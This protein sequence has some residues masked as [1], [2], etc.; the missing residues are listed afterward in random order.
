GRGE[1]Y[2]DGWSIGSIGPHN[3][4]INPAGSRVYMQVLTLPYVFIAE[5]KTNQ[6][7]G[8]VG[9][10]S[11]GVRPFTVTNDEKYVFGNVDPRSSPSPS[12][13]GSVSAWMAST[14]STTPT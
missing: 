11:K 7:I 4:W 12:A 14:S 6:I 5:T 10:F 13:R 3:T 8:K 1:N 2:T 9:P